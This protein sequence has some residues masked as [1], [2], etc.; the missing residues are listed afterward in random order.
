MADTG[1][2]MDD[3]EKEGEGREGEASPVSLLAD[4]LPCLRNGINQMGGGSPG[5]LGQPH[6]P[7]PK[8]NAEHDLSNAPDVRAVQAQTLLQYQ[9]SLTIAIDKSG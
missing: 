9:V 7:K 6:R 1:W 2:M 3:R 5:H 8:D 4:G